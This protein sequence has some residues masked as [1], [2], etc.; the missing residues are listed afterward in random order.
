MCFSLQIF[1]KV[2]GVPVLRMEIAAVEEVQTVGPIGCNEGGLQGQEPQEAWRRHLS[3]FVRPVKRKA[4]SCELFIAPKGEC[5]G[6]TVVPSEAGYICHKEVAGLKTPF[7]LPIECFPTHLA[8]IE[9]DPEAVKSVNVMFK[10]KKVN[11]SL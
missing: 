2:F 7:D 10:S 8:M 9:R 6:D 5:S 3:Q 4:E 11:C 1:H